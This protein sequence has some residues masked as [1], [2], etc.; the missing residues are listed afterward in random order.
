MC[1]LLVGVDSV[2]GCDT[3]KQATSVRQHHSRLVIMRLTRQPV[4]QLRWQQSRHVVMRL[5]RS[6]MQKKQNRLVVMELKR[7]P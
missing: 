2:E 7:S 5:K 6:P 1:C 3:S 4:M